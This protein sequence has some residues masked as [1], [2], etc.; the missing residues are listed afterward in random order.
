VKNFQR[1]AQEVLSSGDVEGVKTLATKAKA[2]TT[3]TA[4]TIAKTEAEPSAF[5][6]G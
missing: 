5:G 6:E 1:Q 2:T 3:A 4:S